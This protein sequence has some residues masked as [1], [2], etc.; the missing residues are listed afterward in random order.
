MCLLKLKRPRKRRPWRIK[1]SDGVSVKRD[2]DGSVWERKS[3]E[4]ADA[5][6]SVQGNG[7]EGGG[8]LTAVCGEGEVME[9]QRSY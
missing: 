8:M 5:D 6:R 3:E 4:G 2:A 7:S 1:S 9:E